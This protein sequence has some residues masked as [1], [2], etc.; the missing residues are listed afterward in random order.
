MRPPRAVL[1]ALAAVSLVT[2][3]IVADAHPLPSPDV[4]SGPSA[5]ALA[6]R[7]TE[8][9][10]GGAAPRWARR[11]D[12]IVAGH[13]MSVV[14][15]VDGDPWYRHRPGVRRPPASNEK[16]LLTMALL[17][18]L[19]T[20][21]TIPTRAMAEAIPR[22]GIV[23]GPM[24]LVGRGDPEVGR[25]DLRALSAELAAG[26]LTEVRGRI[27]GATTPFVRDWFARGWKSYFPS[28]YVARPTALT[29][30]GNR[31]SGG[32]HLSD[33][34]RRAAVIFRRTLRRAGI[35]VGGDAGTKA[36]PAGLRT[37][38][39]TRSA[40]LIDIVTR[41]NRVSSNFRAEVLGKHLALDRSGVG[42][43]PGTGRTIRTF[44]AARGERVAAF[45]GSGLSYDNRVTASALTRLLWW[46][47]D[48]S[49]GTAMMDTLPSGGEGTL[50]GRLEDVTVL[51][52]TGTL[53]EVSAL[54]GWVWLEREARW[55]AF[56]ILSQG[57][58]TS[59]S[60]RL[61]DRIVGAVA[62]HA[63]APT[64]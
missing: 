61:E 17:A 19:G 20:G 5:P 41:M 12:E 4:G 42:S 14:V 51:A 29:Y 55:A 49:W 3:S 63:T 9:D 53:I 28:V 10:P 2:T 59:T 46:A 36:A 22:D 43:I 8:R 30:D 64:S 39:I 1:A 48:R 40:P 26:G 47:E 35:A 60:K 25:A 27:L 24:W 54:S 11:L 34:E 62:L 16:L 7:A 23:R 38:A 13:P 50:A 56:S 21:R 58:S 31:G 18:H 32:G 57:M 15:G 37:L 44:A 45:D 33:P 6:P 52:K